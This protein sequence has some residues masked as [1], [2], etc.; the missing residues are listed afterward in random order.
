MY[1]HS[2]RFLVDPSHPLTPLRRDARGAAIRD[3]GLVLAVGIGG[4]SYVLVM[5][6]SRLMSIPGN[7]GSWAFLVGVVVYFGATS[8]YFQRQ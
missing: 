5:L 1:A 6:V 8:W 7:P 4:V 3:R 2:G